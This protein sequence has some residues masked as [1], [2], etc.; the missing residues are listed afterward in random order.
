MTA[1]VWDLD[2]RPWNE[3]TLKVHV[4]QINPNKRFCCDMALGKHVSNKGGYSSNMHSECDVR[5]RGRFKKRGA[6]W[7]NI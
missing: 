3:R 1:L 2:N 7:V 4:R 5:K 6:R